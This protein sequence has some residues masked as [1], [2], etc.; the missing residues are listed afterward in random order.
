MVPIARW[1]QGG[2][3]ISSPLGLGQAL[4]GP[5]ALLWRGLGHWSVGGGG[6]PP[7]SEERGKQ[8][9]QIKSCPSGCSSL[10]R[11]LMSPGCR[12][13]A[14]VFSH[15]TREAPRTQRRVFESRMSRPSCQCF[16][17]SFHPPPR[18]AGLSSL[19][20]FT[21]KV[22]RLYRKGPGQDRRADERSWALYPGPAGPC[23]ET[24][25]TT[26]SNPVPSPTPTRSLDLRSYFLPHPWKRR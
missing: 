12:P 9:G 24:P 13:V 26:I 21:D 20:H 23:R 19:A 4:A 6:G 25:D 8:K 16:P 5:R 11:T 22:R 7:R 18:E 17:P 1:K 10:A 2:I 3:Y 15:F 14:G